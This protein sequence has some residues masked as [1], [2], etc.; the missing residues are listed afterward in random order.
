[1]LKTPGTSGFKITHGQDYSR[2]WEDGKELV[3]LLEDAKNGN[4]ELF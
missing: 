4:A 3:P 1:M 2:D